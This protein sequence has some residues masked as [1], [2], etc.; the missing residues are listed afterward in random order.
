M[1]QRGIMG[2]AHFIV[3]LPTCQMAEDIWDHIKHTA[4]QILGTW[5]VE[6]EQEM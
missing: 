2:F 6:Y 5:H 4:E 3:K 1:R